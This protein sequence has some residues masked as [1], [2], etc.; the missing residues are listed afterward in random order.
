[1]RFRD[2]MGNVVNG[3]E[4][5]NGTDNENLTENVNAL[6]MPPKQS[7][8]QKNNYNANNYRAQLLL[9]VNA[10]FIFCEKTTLM[11]AKCQ[12]KICVNISLR[13]PLALTFER[14]N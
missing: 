9:G 1:M 12:K 10:K 6:N 13:D 5:Q 14:R 2:E 3:Y 8:C 7:Y 4:I 11:T